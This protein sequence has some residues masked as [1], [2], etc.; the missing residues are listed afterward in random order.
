M[1]ESLPL[2]AG[3]LGILAGDHLKA[4]SNTGLPLVGVGLLY[5]QGYFRQFLN[6]EGYQQEAYPETDF[7]SLPL[8]RMR[9]ATGNE[10]RVSIRGADGPIHAMV[11]KVLIGRVPLFLL[12]TNI[13][14]NPPE[15]REVTARLY[16]AEAKIRLAQEVLLGI[17]GMRASGPWASNRRSST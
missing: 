4:S 3:G 11:W 5:R 12:D 2:F 9:D 17:G 8:Q 13:L 14:E 6:H 1:H 15:H 10:I 16:A 7:Y